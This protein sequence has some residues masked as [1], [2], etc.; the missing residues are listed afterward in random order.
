MIWRSIHYDWPS[1]VLLAFLGLLLAWR[2]IALY[3]YR[4]TVLNEF[5]EPSVMHALLERRHPFIYVTKACLC[6]MI[7]LCAAFALMQPKGNSRYVSP[8]VSKEE[9]SLPQE[10]RRKKMHE[11]LL[12]IDASA[13]MAVT[14]AYS[15]VTRL[16]AAKEIA[17]TIVSGLKGENVSLFA[18]T[19][20]TMQ[21]VPSTT[22]YLF[23]RLMLREVEI[24]EGET[25]GT[26]I[27]Q[28]LETVRQNSFS[29]SAPKP[30]TLILLSDGGDT[31]YESAEGAVQQTLLDQIIEPLADAIDQHLHV[32]VVGI[33]SKQGRDVPGVTYKGHAVL[34]T[35]DEG[36]LKKIS[37]AGQGNLF[38]ANEMTSLQTAKAVLE[39]ISQQSTYE[40][41]SAMPTEESA[42][43]LVYDLY[44]QIP[45]GLALLAFAAVLLL[46]DT[47]RQR[48]KKR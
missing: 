38:L 20:A 40:E 48:V 12:L 4:R 42:H 32:Q 33:G 10:K 37:V 1:A 25:A 30:K 13:S 2:F 19:S 41:T 29:K 47:S 26:D 39:A 3:Q 21:L 46:P 36:L 45:L 31:A 15:G 43:E 24:N 11:I 22:D 23:A 5:A 27:R 7:W 6:C 34:S 44:Y 35:L 14:D 17:D 16:S 8:S 28:A 9:S 18:F